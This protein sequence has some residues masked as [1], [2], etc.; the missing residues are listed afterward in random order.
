[1]ADAKNSALIAE[2]C[3]RHATFS[4]VLQQ[5]RGSHHRALSRPGYYRRSVIRLLRGTFARSSQL[6]RSL[7]ASLP[8]SIKASFWTCFRT[9]PQHS[10]CFLAFLERT[11]LSGSPAWRNASGQA[12]FSRS[13]RAYAL[14]TVSTSAGALS[15]SATSRCGASALGPKRP[16]RP[17]LA[18]S[19]SGSLHRPSLGNLHGCHIGLRPWIGCGTHSGPALVRRRIPIACSFFGMN[20]VFR[21][22]CTHR[23]CASYVSTWLNRASPLVRLSSTHYIT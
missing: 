1:M 13:V 17:S 22:L 19:A 8:T 20:Q 2:L 11:L 10:L 21:P 6:W 7:G 3:E 18:S 23:L 4:E 12:P 5:L 15:A 9:V 14:R 16:A